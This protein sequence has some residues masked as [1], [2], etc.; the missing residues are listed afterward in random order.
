MVEELFVDAANLLLPHHAE[1]FARRGWTI[2][3]NAMSSQ[4]LARCDD[5]CRRLEANP[6]MF[7]T[8]GSVPNSDTRLD[9]LDPVTDLSP[10]FAKL[11]SEMMGLA[12]TVLG[13]KAR[14]IKDKLIYKPPGAGGYGLH[15]D[16]AYFQQMDFSPDQAFTLCVALDP[17]TQESGAVE[18]AKGENWQLLTEPGAVADP[19]AELF[20]SYDH[21]C[22]NPGDLILFS[23]LAP[24]RSAENR[25]SHSRRQLYLLYAT[26]S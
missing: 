2:I 12:S 6:E 26:Q 11:A 4:A 20:S 8:R 23:T 18:F 13:A 1:Q 7:G 22:C 3:P 19:P 16:H 25:S 14:L 9:R 24:H 5:E 15:Q 17:A 21:A 10:V